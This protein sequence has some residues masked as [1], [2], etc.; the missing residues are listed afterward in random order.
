[1]ADRL[2]AQAL[3]QPQLTWRGHQQVGTAH[4]IGHLL[5]NIIHDHGQLVGPEAVCPQQHEVAD[6][7]LQLLGVM[8]L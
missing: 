3:P 4:D 5:L 8:A 7:A 2:P 6:I 1:M